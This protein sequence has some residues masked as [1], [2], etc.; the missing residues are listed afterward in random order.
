[1]RSDEMFRQ[2]SFQEPEIVNKKIQ[3]HFIFLSHS[4]SSYNK[5]VAKWQ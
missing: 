4:S 3:F 1:M 2:N 5:N